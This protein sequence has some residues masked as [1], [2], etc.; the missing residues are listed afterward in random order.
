M[1]DTELYNEP[2]YEIESWERQ[3]GETKREFAAFLY[4]WGWGRAALLL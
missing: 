2:E 1:S 3:D 4:Y